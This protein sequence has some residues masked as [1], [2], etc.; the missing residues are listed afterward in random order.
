MQ[1]YIISS[2]INPNT[3]G[4]TSNYKNT[5]IKDKETYNEAMSQH[6]LNPVEDLV[7]VL[8]TPIKLAKSSSLSR[9]NNSVN[10]AEGQRIRVNGGHV[11]TVT[12]HGVE[13][14]GGDNPYDTQSYVKAQRMADALASMLRNAGGTMT[15]VA[16]SKEEYARYT[17]GIT[18]VMSYLGVDT[19]KDFT[20]NGMKYSKN[21]DGWYESE[22][23]SDA[24]AAYEQLK[25]NNR[26]YQFAD[27]KTK[28]Q[29]A[30]ISDY[31]LQ[32]VPE[33]VKAAW[34][35]TLEE[36]RFYMSMNISG[37]G[38]TYNGINTNSKQYKA[39]KEKGWLSGI[40]QNEAMMSAE[41][42]LIYETFGGRDTII[43]NLMKQ[44]DSDGDLL[45]ANGVAGMDVTGKG[46][47]WQQLTSVS[48]EYRQ[49]MFDN[50]KREFIKEN[51]ISNGDTT[52]RSDIFKDY[53]LSVSKDKR[54]SGTWTLE[55]YEGQYRAAMYAA[56]KSANPN[57]KPGQKF[58]TSILDNVTRESVE[59]T[60]VKNG[61]R[62]VRNSIDVSV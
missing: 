3:R 15:T 27:E 7:Q 19:S 41:E 9:Q 36:R 37:L 25:A 20:V 48:E 5:A 14:S 53:Q 33:S 26:T 1:G 55:Q 30:Y 40:M 31:Y 57:W 24:Q 44:F 28:K 50:V 34:Q 22:A 52:K 38:N 16:H 58:D 18:D 32:T 21:K 61:N 11:L 47:S 2:Y 8:K 29:I 42:R 45:N 10:I 17:E 43:K 49:K 35:E 12:A 51:G 6:L 60:L 13:V 23:N 59:S 56:V 54:L 62:L 39:L 46:T 4:L